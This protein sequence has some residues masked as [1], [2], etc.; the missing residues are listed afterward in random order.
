[1]NVPTYLVAQ[2]IHGL[3]FTTPILGTKI[4]AMT[5]ENEVPKNK[6]F[7]EYHRKKTYTKNSKN[8]EKRQKDRRKTF[9]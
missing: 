6:G 3:H 9:I 5:A 4:R 8:C 1:M 7:E 2:N